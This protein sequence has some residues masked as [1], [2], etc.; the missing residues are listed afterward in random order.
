[1]TTA[2]TRSYWQSEIETLARSDLN[3]L[4]AERLRA[5]VARCADSPFYR[6]LW[7]GNVQPSD[8]RTNRDVVR[9]PFLHKRDL[10]EAQLREPP[11]GDLPVCQSGARREIYPFPAGGGAAYSAYAEADLLRTAQI[12]ARILWGCGLR[13][14]DLVHNGFSYGLF[15]GGISMH[16]AI[17]I[18]GA[19]VVPIG[20]DSV[21]RQVEMLFN[22]RPALVIGTPSHLLYLAERIRERGLQPRDIGL[23]AVL[24]GAEPGAAGS[25][26]RLQQLFGCLAYD[27]Y[28]S[29]EVGAL[30]G[31]ECPLQQGI[32]WAED[33]VR[34][35]IIDP[36]RYE[37]CRPGERG[38]LVLTDLTRQDMPL[39]RYWTGDL[40]TLAEEPCPCGRTHA[41]SIGGI[42]GRT[43]DL[44]MYRGRKFYPVQVER[45]LASYGSLSDEYRI[46]LERDAG[47]W[48][49]RATVLVE[50]APGGAATAHSL[51]ERVERHLVEELEAEISVKIVQ[52]GSL[53]RS[54]NKP[55][56]VD[57]R[58]LSP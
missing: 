14:G 37:R 47:A 9:L 18:L 31:A 57:D 38:I 41:R 24:Y 6:R 46:V 12:G 10:L 26:S 5:Q 48:A 22:F 56:R 7:Q 49:D 43:D 53:E 42:R 51:E 23:R 21:K 45:I 15:A 3:Q 8:I 32:H 36:E 58:R 29:T 34:V 17:H 50:A 16:R 4:Q 28:G 39:L 2:V 20:T 40:A 33:H 1:M 30:L 27:F 11:L 35:E 25:R 13:P 54:V 19:A 52:Y 44:V 55:R